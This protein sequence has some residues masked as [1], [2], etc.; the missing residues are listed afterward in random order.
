MPATKLLKLKKRLA[1]YPSNEQITSTHN[2][3]EKADNTK[4]RQNQDA[5]ILMLR[6]S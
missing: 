5:A 4:G 6:R 1:L 2:Y 3:P